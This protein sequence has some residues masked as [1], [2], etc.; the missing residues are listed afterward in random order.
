MAGTRRLY[1]C[2]ADIRQINLLAELMQPL[3]L[4]ADGASKSVLVQ[5]IE[6]DRKLARYP[7]YRIARPARKIFEGAQLTLVQQWAE[8]RSERLGEITTQL[9]VP[10]HY[11]AGLV[12]LN[13]TSYR[14][15]LELLCLGLELA[16]RVLQ[17]TKHYLAC[18]RPASYSPSIQPVI[19]PRRFEA[20][21][22]GHATEAFFVARMLSH[23][24]GHR[25]DQPK[26]QELDNQLQRLATR[27][28]NNRIISGVHFHIDSVA[29]RMVGETLAEYL[30]YR[31]DPSSDGWKP[32]CFD[33]TALVGDEPMLQRGLDRTEAMDGSKAQ[34]Y[35]Q[36][37]GQKPHRRIR[38]PLSQSL[39]THSG[40]AHEAGLLNLLWHEAASE[41][42]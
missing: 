29:G 16:Y 39:V 7:I 11:W 6:L 14:R 34:P 4:S 27:I 3:H 24:A 28:A 42:R 12:D 33:G 31:C 18:P 37:P 40:Q 9:G 1:E 21:P 2:S 36:W 41:W 38:P 22:S 26:H 10:L 15:T 25:A 32:R 20:F 13:P 17:P 19:R 35:F 30:I 23:L 5:H 8:L